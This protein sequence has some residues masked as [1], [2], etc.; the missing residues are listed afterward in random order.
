MKATLK[1]WGGSLAIRLPKKHIDTLDMKEGDSFELL[2]KDNGFELIKEGF[3][4]VPEDIRK[5]LI[6]Y[7]REEIAYKITLSVIEVYKRLQNLKD[8]E[9]LAWIL[10]EKNLIKLEKAWLNRKI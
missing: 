9:I 3:E 7:Q 2:L 1:S 6:I 10:E 5:K 8:P 4:L